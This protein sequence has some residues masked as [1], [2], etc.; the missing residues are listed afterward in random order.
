MCR[1]NEQRDVTSKKH[2][3]YENNPEELEKK[4]GTY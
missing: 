4:D 2:R 3:T 1:Q